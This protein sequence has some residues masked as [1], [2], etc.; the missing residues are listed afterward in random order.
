[1]AWAAVAAGTV[2]GTWVMVPGEVPRTESR[3]S[4]APAE[5]AAGCDGN[6]RARCKNMSYFLKYPC[7]A[8]GCCRSIRERNY[9]GFV[10]RALVSERQSWAPKAGLVRSPS[11]AD[12]A[13]AAEPRGCHHRCVSRIPQ[14]QGDTEDVLDEAPPW[15]WQP[16]GLC[17]S[18]TH[19]FLGI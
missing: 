6:S 1:M 13:V 16:R 15:C 4:A 14:S 10:S 11:W 17:P 18:M 5:P 2:T 12:R 3:C 9:P 8:R 7:A 19:S